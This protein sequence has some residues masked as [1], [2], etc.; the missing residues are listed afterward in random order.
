LP[1]YSLSELSLHIRDTLEENYPE[2]IW[3]TA[4]INNLNINSISGH[5]YLE[6]S[7]GTG[8]Q[9][10]AKA[11]IWKKTFEVIHN[12]FRVQTG[13]ELKKGINIQIL[14]KVEFNIQYG[15]S[16]IVWDID[17]EFSLGQA[18]KNRAE[19][20]AKI[21]KEGLLDKNK[22]LDIPSI[23]QNF[24]I[25]S[26]PTAAGYQDF[27][28]HLKENPFGFAFRGKL[29]SAK[30]QGADGVE[31]IVKAFEEIKNSEEKFEVIILIRGGGSSLDLQLFDEYE[32]ARE[33]AE[34]TL[35]VLTGIGHERDDSVAD[36][37]ASIRLKTPTA[38]A[39]FLIG[40]MADA[41]GN[42]MLTCQ[43]ISHKLQSLVQQEIAEFQLLVSQFFQLS[44]KNFAQGERIFQILPH[45]IS[46]AVQTRLQ[47]IKEEYLKI[48]NQLEMGN[49]LE[50]LK[51]GYA[52]VSQ[53][54][55][56]IS[57]L[58]EISKLQPINLQMQDGKIQLIV[59]KE[60]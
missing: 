53:N 31:S 29:F 49:P 59:Q 6:L 38:V 25:I 12:K 7:D 22:N 50:I 15:L 17:T 58:K 39:D 1:V 27:V 48:E 13:M 18:A 46:Q 3:I 26:S 41:E 2:A 21:Q 60:S 16:L 4:E 14:V 36:L 45:K 57:S 8:Q 43:E 44:T 10:R 11:M 24:A 23:I 35:P 32:I 37:V 56:R 51:K 5:C 33:I 52:I 47:E 54:G 42:V 9:A 30:M 28:T 20:I 55:K 19:V 40:K 34:S